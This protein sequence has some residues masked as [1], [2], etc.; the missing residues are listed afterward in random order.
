LTALC[1]ETRP[2]AKPQNRWQQFMQTTQDDIQD[3]FSM[4]HD[5]ELKTVK[6]ENEVLTLQI[7]IPWS[8]LW[9]NDK[10]Y[11]IRLEV[12]G[13]KYFYCDY[14]ERIHNGPFKSFENINLD[15]IEYSTKDIA[16]IMSL[17]LSIQS[18]VFKSPNHYIFYC[19][20][21]EKI[22][23]GQLMFTTDSY[24]L[25]DENDNILTLDKMKEIAT[26][27]WDGIQNMWDNQ[28]G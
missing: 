7:E 27:W 17:R 10:S 12:H 22:D 24:K 2:T 28:K 13:C 25:F 5:F 3:L 11:E 20:G 1:S 16:T 19:N 8:Q 15:R 4:F 23:E 26:L 9:D 6:Y 18:H 21:K 14:Q